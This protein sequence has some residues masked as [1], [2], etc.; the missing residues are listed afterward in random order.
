V[1]VA[2][3]GT[4][5]GRYLYQQIDTET[6]AEWGLQIEQF[7]DRRD[8][9]IKA[10]PTTGAPIKADLS[11]TD[12][13]FATAQQAVID[14]ATEALSQGAKNGNFQI[15]PVDTEQI[16]FGRDYFVGDRVTISV[17]GTEYQDIVREVSITVDQ[18]GQTETITPTIGEQ[19]SGNPLNIY[20]TV[21]E[22]REKLRKL[23]ARK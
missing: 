3:Q 11:V 5:K 1:I 23:E 19:G 20:K 17:D 12:E 7:L 21:F 9:P 2:C 14:A 15:Y 10:D 8:L 22:M 6:E 18:G 16:K 4:G 13:Q